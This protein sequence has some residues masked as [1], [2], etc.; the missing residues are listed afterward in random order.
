MLFRRGGALG[1]MAVA[2]SELCLLAMWSRSSARSNLLLWVPAVTKVK[3]LGTV[4]TGDA[5]GRLGEFCR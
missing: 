3:D 1:P 2:A 4:R 5:A